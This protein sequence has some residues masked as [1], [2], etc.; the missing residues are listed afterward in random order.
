MMLV[1]FI[2]FFFFLVPL[3]ISFSLVWGEIDKKN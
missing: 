1:G 2:F 3:E